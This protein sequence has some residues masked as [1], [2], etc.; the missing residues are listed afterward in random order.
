MHALTFHGKGKIKYESAPDPEIKSP[1]DAIIKVHLAGICGSDLHV[2]HEREKGLDLG[3]IMG[4]E[5]VGEIV[6]RGKDVR[7][8]RQG[9]LVVSPFTTNCGNCFYC[10]KGLTS[11]CPAGQLLGWVQKG[12]GLQG[13]QA[14]YVRVPLADSSLFQVPEKVH[15]EAGLLMGDVLPTGYFCADMAEITPEGTYVSIGCGPVGLMA[16]LSAREL[17]AEKIY[18]IDKIPERLLL[19]AKFGAKPI[20]FEHDDPIMIL[21]EATEGRGTDAVL[22]VVGNSAA[23]RLAID[24]VRPGGVIAVAGV[25]NEPHF[26]FSPAEAYDKNLTYKV[27]RCPAR[28]YAQRLIPLVQKR[29]D[30]LLAIISHRL[31]LAQGPK[32]YQIFDEKLEDCTKVVLMP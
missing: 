8:F 25:H 31:P 28:H 3:A 29:Q 26:P 27:G 17:G 24:L 2:Y 22:E 11:R 4:H 18:A 6:E 7:N 23:T 1:G 14:E 32:G 12:I 9:D 20:N 21:R 13:T 16:I 10:R 19:A 5:L 15:T 30:E